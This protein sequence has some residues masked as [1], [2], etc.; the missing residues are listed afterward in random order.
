[1]RLLLFFAHVVI[2]LQSSA[3]VCH[4][5]LSV[6]CD[7]NSHILLQNDCL[8]LGSRCFQRNV[9]KCLNFQLDKLDNEIEEH[10][11]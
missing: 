11:S 3:I 10:S 2:V 7:T 5:M 4:N 8:K 9:A 1:M 6:V